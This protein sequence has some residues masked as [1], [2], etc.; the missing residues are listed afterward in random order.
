MRHVGRFREGHGYEDPA[1]FD[2]AQLLRQLPGRVV[3]IEVVASFFQTFDTFRGRDAAGGDDQKIVIVDIAAAGLE[4]L[5]REIKT[6][7]FFNVEGDFR[8]QQ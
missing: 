4:A 7:H 3:L 2:G 1:F 5:P 6:R 8:A